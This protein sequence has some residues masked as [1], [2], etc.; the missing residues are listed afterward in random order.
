MKQLSSKSCPAT[1]TTA[2]V[3]RAKVT[4]ATTG[5]LATGRRATL[6]SNS[7]PV[8][9]LSPENLLRV[10]LMLGCTGLVVCAVVCHPQTRSV[11]PWQRSKQSNAMQYL[12][13]QPA[14]N[15]Q[16]LLQMWPAR[17]VFSFNSEMNGIAVELIDF[18]Q[19]SFGAQCPCLS[20][21]RC[22]FPSLRLHILSVGILIHRGASHLRICPVWQFVLLQRSPGLSPYAGVVSVVVD[23]PVPRDRLP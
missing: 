20:L 2:T 11:S 13:R 1:V 22:A 19:F 8:V 17:L 14:P 10:H 16:K 21:H 7:I 4:L 6:D 3:T 9:I 12:P 15:L 5:C 18:L 23:S